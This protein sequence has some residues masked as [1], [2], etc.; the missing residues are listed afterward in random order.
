MRSHLSSYSLSSTPPALTPLPPFPWVFES[1]P[2]SVLERREQQAV[3]PC[4]QLEHPVFLFDV[5]DTLIVDPFWVCKPSP[6]LLLLLLY[7]Y[8]HNTWNTPSTCS[9]L[10]LLLLL[11]P[12]ARPLPP[13]H[14]WTTTTQR[15]NIHNITPPS[16]HKYYQWQQK[17]TS[18]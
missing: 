1:L 9:R 4:P 3:M 11:L 13:H 16:Q 18:L 14:N 12:P 7:H 6:L 10:D 5:M 15:S 8:M 2:A 17:L